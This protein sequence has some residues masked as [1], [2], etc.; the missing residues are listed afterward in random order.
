M[1]CCCDKLQKQL[2]MAVDPKVVASLE[3]L[4]KM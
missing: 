3:P 2:C 4:T 1:E